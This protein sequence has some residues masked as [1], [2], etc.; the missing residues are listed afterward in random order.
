MTKKLPFE[1]LDYGRQTSNG[2]STNSNPDSYN[3]SI[4]NDEVGDE[5]MSD[6]SRQISSPRQGNDR[7]SPPQRN[8]GRLNFHPNSGRP[9]PSDFVNRPTASSPMSPDIND[10][11][12]KY[13]SERLKT[14]DR[15]PLSYIRPADLANAGFVYTGR[16]D[17][18]RCVFCQ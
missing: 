16:G 18:V 14:F 11:I 8:A 3:E 13:E 17:C 10:D 12:Y 2:N 4:G 7:I 5:R 1:I 6:N 9:L 15:W